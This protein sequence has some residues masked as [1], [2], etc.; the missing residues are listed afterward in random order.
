[1]LIAFSTLM[2]ILLLQQVLFLVYHW[3]LIFYDLDNYIRYH[4]NMV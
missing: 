2:M 3:L 1:M 4:K